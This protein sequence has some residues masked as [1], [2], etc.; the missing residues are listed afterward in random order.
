M[1]CE[2]YFSDQLRIKGLRMTPQR[3]IILGVVHRL[4]GLATAEDIYEKVKQKST[5][6]NKSTVYRTLE[7]L[8]ELKLITWLHQDDGKRCYEICEVNSDHYHAICKKC[9]A[10]LGIESETVD[11]FS[12]YL[13]KK[14]E[15]Q[16][17][18][19][20]LTFPGLCK[21]CSQEQLSLV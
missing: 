1:S 16:L 13:M 5:A 2:N 15:F 10:M 12:N 8:E 18:I 7:L 17:D 14:Y 6:V 20:N 21:I 4:N 3:E 9:G 11:A 19:K